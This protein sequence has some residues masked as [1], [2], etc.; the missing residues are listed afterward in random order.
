MM[1]QIREL[2]SK[3]DKRI[4]AATKPRNKNRAE[5]IMPHHH[6]HHHQS[7][8]KATS[9]QQQQSSSKQPSSKHQQNCSNKEPAAA[10]SASA[11]LNTSKSE[12]FELDEIEKKADKRSEEVRTPRRATTA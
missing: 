5:V 9:K 11:S 2:N 6:H 12:S 10:K 4:Q 3:A 8:S 7:S 1:L